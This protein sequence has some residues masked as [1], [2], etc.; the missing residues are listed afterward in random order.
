MRD[1]PCKH[2][3]CRNRQP[4]VWWRAG[5][6]FARTA[7]AWWL[8]L[9]AHCSQPWMPSCSPDWPSNPPAPPPC[10]A[11]AGSNTPLSHAASDHHPP[12]LAGA[13]G[14]CGPRR[15][16]RRPCPAAHPRRGDAGGAR[17]RPAGSPAGRAGAA[18]RVWQGRHCRSGGLPTHP[19]PPLT[20]RR[21]LDIMSSG[22]ISSPRAAHISR[23][24]PPAMQGRIRQA[25]LVPVPTLCPPS[26][27]LTAAGGPGGGAGRS[28]WGRG[29]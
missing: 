19:T 11:A 25:L 6:S 9:L 12:G 5:G 14:A 24:R 23:L 13:L 18:G 2:Q 1:A 28:Q 29:V 8:G 17:G 26:C 15:R 4:A 20:T 7:V 16:R 22:L 27:P 3:Q 10:P 21:P